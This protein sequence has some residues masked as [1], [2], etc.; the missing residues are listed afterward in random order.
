M[1][2]INLILLAIIILSFAVGIYA[3]PQ[4]PDQVASH[5]NAQGE[6]D[7]YMSKFWGVF[8]MPI[9]SIGLFFLFFFIPKIDP[10][11]ANIAKFRKYFDA[12]IVLIF[13]FLFYVFLLTILWN[14]GMRFDMTLSI[15]PALAVLFYFIGVLIENTKRNWFIGI[16]TPWTLSSD[17]VWE[18][19]HQVGGKLFRV[20]GVLTLIGVF[21]SDYLVYFV[22]VPAVSV[23]IFAFAYSYFLYQKEIE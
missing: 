2:K 16:R 18:K 1:K 19:T 7:G 9:I 15:I 8:L 5:W 11:K 17:T 23:A 22:V 14:M 3:Y 4:M 20:V 10:L 21:F 6:V 12:F 13:L